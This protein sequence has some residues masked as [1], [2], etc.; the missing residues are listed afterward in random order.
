MGFDVEIT[1]GL[2]NP[3]TTRFLNLELVS[4]S[5]SPLPVVHAD[6]NRGDRKISPRF[7]HRL[8]A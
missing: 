3:V 7:Y 1:L 8:I 5:L 4:R 2:T 6:S